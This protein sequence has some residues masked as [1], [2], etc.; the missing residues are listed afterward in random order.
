MPGNRVT[1]AQWELIARQL[2]AGGTVRRVAEAN[3]VNPATIMRRK[4]ADAD[5]ARRTVPLPGSEQLSRI[6]GERTYRRKPQVER[7]ETS[8][9]RG[10]EVEAPS[11]RVRE[12][13][14]ALDPE[15]G[16]KVRPEPLK[17]RSRALRPIF[18]GRPGSPEAFAASPDVGAFQ[19][20]D[21]PE[22]WL[23]ERDAARERRQANL[24]AGLSPDGMRS[25]T[26]LKGT[27]S[28]DP[29]DKD[30]CVRAQKIIAQDGLA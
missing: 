18:L 16:F 25:V 13:V 19:R 28:Y 7:A 2:A 23:D 27:F 29:L 1:D 12:Q 21:P 8:V 3:G 6:R 10:T 24:K 26:T 11:G 4:K 22:D 5:F 9:P 17:P 30:D 14:A 20:S 15:T